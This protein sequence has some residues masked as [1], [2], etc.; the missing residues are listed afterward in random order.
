MRKVRL[1]VLDRRIEII[2][3]GHLPNHLNSENIRAGISKF[4]NP[5]LASYVAKGVCP[6]VAWVPESRARCGAGRRST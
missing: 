6:I 5:I 3:T 2:S 4:R 1:F